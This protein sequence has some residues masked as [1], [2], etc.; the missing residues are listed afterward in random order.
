MLENIYIADG[1][2]IYWKTIVS[3]ILSQKAEDQVSGHVPSCLR[4]L[5]PKEKKLSEKMAMSLC[6]LYAPKKR[7]NESNNIQALVISSYL[8]FYVILIMQLILYIYF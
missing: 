8:I 7:M 4:I 1:S 2:G 3:S 6:R 5:I